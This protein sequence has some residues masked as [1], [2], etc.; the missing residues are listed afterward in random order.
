MAADVDVVDN[1]FYGENHFPAEAG[2]TLESWSAE[3]LQ[4]QQLQTERRCTNRTLVSLMDKAD[5]HDVQ[6]RLVLHA[7]PWYDNPD[8][9]EQAAYNFV[10][11]AVAQQRDVVMVDQFIGSS[12]RPTQDIEVV[13]RNP[14]VAKRTFHNLRDLYGG[15]TVNIKG[16]QFFFTPAET[17][18]DKLRK[19]PLKVLLSLLGKMNFNLADLNK[20]WSP[21]MYLA[22]KEG[23]IMAIVTFKDD[24]M[25]ATVEIASKLYQQLAKDFKAMWQEKYSEDERR[26]GHGS[27]DAYPWMFV[28]KPLLADMKS[29]E[30]DHGAGRTRV[31]V[32]GDE[33]DS[34]GFRVAGPPHPVDEQEDNEDDESGGPWRSVKQ[35]HPMAKPAASP[36][37]HP[38]TGQLPPCY[39]GARAAGGH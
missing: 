37:R 8:D 35:P 13:C 3:E 18:I 19:R 5:R 39:R 1:N 4:E 21:P 24:A 12:R 10:A 38:R 31:N 20:S 14:T 22:D 25:T 33:F 34:Q 28:M 9:R 29:W 15:T 30:L 16:Q 6:K 23:A 26:S 32:N 7:F 2:P 27:Y 36:Q 17:Y 11:E